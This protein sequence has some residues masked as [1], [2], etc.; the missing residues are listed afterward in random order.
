VSATKAQT[1]SAA[2]ATRVATDAPPDGKATPAPN[3]DETRG[4]KG[5]CTGGGR[6]GGRECEE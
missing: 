3:E 6:Y 4:G 1:V 5:G 2:P